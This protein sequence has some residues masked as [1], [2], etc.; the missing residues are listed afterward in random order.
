M[1]E[2]TEAAA[3]VL[4]RAHHAATRFDPDVRVRIFLRGNE[5]DT[6]FTHSGDP[7]DERLVIGD[8]IV[9]I[10]SDVG[11]GTLDVAEH[12]RLVVRR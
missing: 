2:V 10:A 7:G 4:E 6:G 12:D 8:V 3:E 1:L 11:G 5:I 9:F